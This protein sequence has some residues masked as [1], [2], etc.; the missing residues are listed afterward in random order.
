MCS[1]LSGRIAFPQSL[2]AG[3]CP[4]PRL[5]IPSWVLARTSLRYLARPSWLRTPKGPTHCL[6]RT[7]DS[8]GRT[9]STLRVA[10]A[11]AKRCPAGPNL[12]STA[13]KQSEPGRPEAPC[14][15]FTNSWGDR[16]RQRVQEDLEG[17]TR[18][19]FA[20]L[21]SAMQGSSRFPA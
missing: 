7:Q 20:W 13:A 10:P 2:I 3:L 8:P 18:Q 16:F 17:K 9:H 14:L 4:Q 6:R 11:Q 1:L 15:N 12:S 5:P 19:H 21:P